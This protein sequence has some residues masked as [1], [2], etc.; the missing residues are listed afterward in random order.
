MI[1]H[2]WSSTEYS[3]F[4]EALT[5]CL[6]ERG[7]EAKQRFLISET[8][9]RA[10]KSKPAR[11]WLRIRQY[12][13]YPA[14]L[15]GHLLFGKKADVVVVTTNTFYAPLLATFLHKR[16]VHLVYDL[17]PEAMHP[18][19]AVM[20]KFENGRNGKKGK[21]VTRA[22]PIRKILSLTLK[23]AETNVFLGQ[24]LMDYVESV[25]GKLD[26]AVVIPV[27]AA[28]PREVED[29]K[30]Q[31]GSRTELPS[32]ISHLPSPNSDVMILYCGNLGRMH[33]VK[34]LLDY[35]RSGEF[36]FLYEKKSN[37]QHRSE[38]TPP[39]AHTHPTNHP[40]TQRTPSF[41]FHCSGPRKPELEGVVS[42]LAKEPRSRIH[43]GGGLPPGEW[44]EV[45][46]RS[47]V[48]LV[49]MIDGAE[50]VVMPSKTYAAMMAGQAILA[51]APEAS[52]LVDTIR[53]ADC[54]WWVPPGGGADA[55]EKLARVIEKIH[56][57]PA[58]LRRK[59]ENARE[60]ARAHFS[61]SVLAE[62]WMKLFETENK[63]DLSFT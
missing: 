47:P 55:V 57:D 62:V 25:Y 32:P 12:L 45:M 51:I 52:D 28:E 6:R 42:S 54:G 1:I 40:S 36:T 15:K 11:F 2:F 19:G 24:R 59:R 3:G 30:S 58:E 20:E 18:E 23:R 46:R 27:G 37:T 31:I 38:E 13:L 5:A 34:T 53:A 17:F 49:T 50:N 48:A 10:A 4:M 29:R 22:R 61:M 26:N 35:F 63:N 43:I 16:V 7:Y 14:Y 9:Y 21:G 56:S 60:Y 41:L 8:S 44:E 39:G 33:D